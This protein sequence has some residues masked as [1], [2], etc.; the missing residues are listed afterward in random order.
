[1]RDASPGASILVSHPWADF[2]GVLT[3]RRLLRPVRRVVEL[4]TA[5]TSRPT[6][7]ADVCAVDGILP[8]LCR[9]LVLSPAAPP[10]LPARERTRASHA[11]CQSVRRT[12]V[13][14]TR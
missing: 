12:E 10:S 11:Q 8:Q 5:A 1:M 14:T 6:L 2:A 7:P 13:A 9:A 4:A 3:A